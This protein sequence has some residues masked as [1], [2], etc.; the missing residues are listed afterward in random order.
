M[1][2]WI[3]TSQISAE[4]KQKGKHLNQT[5]FSSFHKTLRLL[6]K[7]KPMSAGKIGNRDK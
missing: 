2:A 3:P 7:Y 5:Y 4:Y 1:Y 6:T